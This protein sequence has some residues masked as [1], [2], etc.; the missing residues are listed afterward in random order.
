MRVGSPLWREGW[1]ERGRGSGANP[2]PCL[3]V[4]PRPGQDGA[5]AG[6]FRRTSAFPAPITASPT[7][8]KGPL[9]LFLPASMLGTPEASLGKSSKFSPSPWHGILED[10]N[11]LQNPG[12][13]PKPVAP[14]FLLQPR[15]FQGSTCVHALSVRHGFSYCVIITSPNVSSL[16]PSLSPTLTP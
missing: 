7:P 4:H 13:S 1:W 11:P 3:T 15:A 8:E 9:S 2:F 16:C 14:S 10:P 12:P 6:E 5:Q